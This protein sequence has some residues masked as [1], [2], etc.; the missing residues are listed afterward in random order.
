MRRSRPWQA[1]AVAGVVVLGLASRRFGMFHEVLGKYPGDV[2]WTLMVYLG[3]GFVFPKWPIAGMTLLA[4]VTSYA[5][6]FA[7]FHHAPWLENFRN[8]TFGHLV[9]GYTFSWGNLLAYTIGAAIGAAGERILYQR[10]ISPPPSVSS[11]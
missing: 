5:V 10:V 3:W 11:G 4:L 8:T 7:K 9:L 1:L 2:L 6:E